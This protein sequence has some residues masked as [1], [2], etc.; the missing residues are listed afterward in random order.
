MTGTAEGGG[1]EVSGLWHGVFAFL[2][3]RIVVTHISSLLLRDLQFL[4][5]ILQGLRILI[6]LILGCL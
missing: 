4:L 5:G 3:G 1:G 2:L 6:E